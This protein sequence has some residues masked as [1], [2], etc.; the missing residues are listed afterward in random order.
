[1]PI[2]IKPTQIVEVLEE[3]YRSPRASSGRHPTVHPTNLV[4]TFRPGHLTFHL[5][6][7]FDLDKQQVHTEHAR[8]LATQDEQLDKAIA[9]HAGP[10]SGLSETA[11]IERQISAVE[12]VTASYQAKLQQARQQANSFY[13]GD[14]VRRSF[15]AFLAAARRH[16]TSSEPRQAWLGAYRAAYE[17]MRLE[18]QIAQL[19]RRRADLAPKLSTARL[20]ARQRDQVD[21]QI[22]KIEQN[23]SRFF[24]NKRELELTS[25]SIERLL[26]KLQHRQRDDIVAET[27]MVHARELE[28]E[29]SDLTQCR[30]KL[31]KCIV[32]APRNAQALEIEIKDIDSTFMSERPTTPYG[33]R[34]ELLALKDQLI[35]ESDTHRSTWPAEHDAANR[36]SAMAQQAI[37]AAFDE[38]M[39]LSMLNGQTPS[40]TPVTFEAWTSSTR[41]ALVLASSRGAVAHFEP[42]WEAFGEALQRLAT[43]V[44]AQGV[45]AAARYAPLMLYS[46]RLGNGERMGVSVPLAWLT[47]DAD[48]T[49]DANRLAGQTLELPLRMNAVPTGTETVVYLA[50]TDGSSVQRDVRVRQAEWDSDQGAYRFTA[51]GPGGATLLWHPATPPSTLSSYDPETGSHIPGLP[52]VEDLRKHTDGLIQVPPELDIRTFPALPDEQPD[53][54][55]IVFPVDAGMAP[56]YVMFRDPR[57]IAGVASG[58]G[59][60]T[61]DR[62][63]EAAVT[64]EGAPIPARIADKLRGRRFSSFDRLREAFW[65]EVGADPEFRQ[66]F[67]LSNQQRVE[68]GSAPHVPAAERAGKRGTFE[69]HHIAEVARGGA[70]YDMDNI[71]IMTPH[72]HIAH[73]SKR[74][75]E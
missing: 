5:V 64:P 31:H 7:Q 2:E 24:N 51:E 41:H 16:K 43:H 69:L 60:V 55:V 66:H 74:S 48:Q 75:E 36:L 11:A 67:T 44:L 14:P 26:A 1:M 62:F 50:A 8:L 63:L 40:N 29:T 30:E 65:R 27:A 28:R 10:L 59:Q 6:K 53:D 21:R 47:P 3:E 34:L 33:R 70:V 35:R 56:I 38:Q 18:N 39:H 13:R 19:H 23:L 73:H 25:V 37:N 20:K 22:H 72:Q 52:I 12:Q 45:A 32:E 9:A 49:L 42:V 71:T 46:T 58:N 57:Q 4:S 68:E 54:Y 17:A 15:D 61:P